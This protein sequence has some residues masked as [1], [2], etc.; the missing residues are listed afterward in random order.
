MALDQECHGHEALNNKEGYAEGVAQ[1]SSQWQFSIFCCG[2]IW[3]QGALARTNC[4]NSCMAAII[5]SWDMRVALLK[6][7][8]LI[9]F[10]HKIKYLLSQ[11][12]SI[13]WD[14][15]N[16]WGR[17]VELQRALPLYQLMRK[18]MLLENLERSREW[19]YFYER[20]FIVLL[21]HWKTTNI[22]DWIGGTVGI[23]KY[24]RFALILLLSFFH[25]LVWFSII[26]LCFSQIFFTFSFIWRSRF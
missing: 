23:T 22:F 9:Y 8:Y 3:V 17:V 15:S 26:V 25:C 4:V 2:T 20:F 11:S 13:V 16:K 7:V 19:V 24:C 14:C 10:V 6:D 18:T 1:T 5:S 12:I 21:N